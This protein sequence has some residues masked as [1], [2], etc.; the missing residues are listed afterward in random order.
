MP[1]EIVTYPRSLHGQTPPISRYN[2]VVDLNTT[3]GTAG[4]FT[5]PTGVNSIRVKYTAGTLYVNASGTTAAAISAAVTDGTGPELVMQ[6]EPFSVAPGQ[7]LSFYNA[8]AC[9]VMISCRKAG[10]S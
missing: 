8:T 2:Q 4:S 7:V 5:V 3:P 6:G 10:L 9:W 1:A